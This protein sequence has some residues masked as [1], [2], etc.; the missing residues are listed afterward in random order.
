MV[1]AWMVVVA[2]LAWVGPAAGA[3]RHRPAAEV[4]VVVAEEGAPLVGIGE[5]PSDEV[6]TALVFLAPAGGDSEDGD[7]AGRTVDAARALADVLGGTTPV[8]IFVAADGDSGRAEALA[9]ALGDGEF[10]AIEIRGATDDATRQMTADGGGFHP[11]GQAAR[12]A[13]DPAAALAIWRNVASYG[14][15]HTPP[16]FEPDGTGGHRQL[17]VPGWDEPT[18]GYACPFPVLLATPAPAGLALEIGVD[19]GRTVPEEAL[20]SWCDSAARELIR[21][22]ASDDLQAAFADGSHAVIDFGDPPGPGLYWLRPDR[23]TP[24]GGLSTDPCITSA[25]TPLEVAADHAGLTLHLRLTDE[26]IESGCRRERLETC[27]E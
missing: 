24:P 8:R 9:R 1:T 15:G 23:V 3:E 17:R 21:S 11:R 5:P 19:G 26:D 16:A 10:G 7:L 13:A 6:I 12:P 27:R 18:A 2:A 22:C 20:A 4:V 25:L 14:Y